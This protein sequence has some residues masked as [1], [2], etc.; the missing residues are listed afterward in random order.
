MERPLAWRS[1]GVVAVLPAGV[2]LM[3]SPGYGYHRDELYFRVLAVC[4]GPKR[5]WSAIWPLWRHFS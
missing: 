5:P 4:R 2:L 1:V 3:V